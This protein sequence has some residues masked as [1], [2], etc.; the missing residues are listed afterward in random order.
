MILCF[1]NLWPPFPGGAE[2][3][4]FNIARDL[5]RRSH[6]VEVLTGYLRA[7]R[8]DG[9]TVHYLPI[10]CGPDHAEGAGMLAGYIDA[11]KPRVILTHHYY[12]TEFESELVATG[13]PIVQVVLNGRRL[14]D[15]ALAIYISRWVYDQLGDAH[16][17]DLLLTPPAFSDVIAAE[18]GDAIGFVKPIPH[19]GVDLVYRLAEALPLRRFV[20]LRGEWQDLEDIRPAPNIEFMEP[21]DDIRDFYRECRLVLMPSLSE[22]AGT[23]AQEATLNGLPCISSNVGGLAETNAGG[24]LLDPDDVV[25]W[26]A[27]ILDLDDPE[28]YAAVTRSQLAHLKA[29]DHTSTMSTIS[30]RIAAL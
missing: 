7:M 23:V 27:R 11:L 2:R 14:P 6:H 12:A 22:D 21:V 30:D 8:F 24:V 19:K 3:L 13:I 4:M 9:P 18:H 25:A 16:P 28:A 17:D 10:G 26:H 5:Y 29:T 1:S 15:A 20:I